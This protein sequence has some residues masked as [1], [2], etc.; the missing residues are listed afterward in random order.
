MPTTTTATAEIAGTNA[1]N[2]QHMIEHHG[3]AIGTT[4]HIVVTGGTP[5]LMDQLRARLTALEA[6]WSRFIDTSEVSQLN[7]EPDRWHVVSPETMLLLERARDGWTM[8]HGAFDPTVLEAVK[9]QGYRTSF[10]KLGGPIPVK[11]TRPSAGCAGIRLDGKASVVRLGGGGSFDP[12]GIGK[13]LA[14]DLLV[15][16]AMEAGASGAM[17]NLGGDLVCRG[18]GPNGD[19]WTIAIDE[20]AVA[21]DRLAIIALD[22][23]AVATSTTKKRRW[24]TDAG[25]RHHLIDPR[26]GENTA[27]VAL[28]TVVAAEGW[29][30]EV[31][32]KQLVVHGLAAPI[33]T[34]R[35]AAL[36]VDDT[37]ARHQIGE[38]ERYLR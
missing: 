4:S 7:V 24:N 18:A 22:N 20:P 5:S 30:A 33:D 32:A 26:S 6:R 16:Q 23:G 36:V 19:P 17:I 1:E 38:I 37:G 11:H 14:A 27:G 31:I 9:A 25:E 10:E 29:W 8:T 35:A 3:R 13:G 28:A 2:V 21:P 15:D 34:K 12:G